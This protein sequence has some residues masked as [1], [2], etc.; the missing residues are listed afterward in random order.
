MEI[1]SDKSHHEI[2]E[3]LDYSRPKGL[4]A[5]AVGLQDGGLCLVLDLGGETSVKGRIGANDY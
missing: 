2:R 5:K 4:S 3:G 1:F